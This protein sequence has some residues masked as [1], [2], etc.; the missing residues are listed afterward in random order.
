[1]MH[2]EAK[3]FTSA[4]EQLAH[5]KAVRDRLGVI[6]RPTNEY[7]RIMAEKKRREQEEADIREAKRRAQTA[8]M[9]AEFARI[10]AERQEQK[11][12]EMLAKMIK[13]REGKEAEARLK[14][15]M[16]ERLPKVI[17][18][19]P[20]DDPDLEEMHASLTP[21]KK[22]S[23]IILE[24][25]AKHGFPFPPIEIIGK[26]R[27]KYLIAIRQECMYEVFIQRPDLSFKQIGMKFRRDH[28]T[29][30][31]GIEQHKKRIGA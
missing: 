25:M 29:V 31:W 9:K 13:E 30:M 22:V 28:S 23:E 8:F 24:V 19:A 15:E 7:Y 20:D 27:F 17:T 6:S 2:M 18:I 12:R 16:N 26:H 5:A 4:A 21:R 10:A 11:Q 3:T 14:A 1:M